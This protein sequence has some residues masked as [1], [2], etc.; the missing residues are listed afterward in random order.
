MSLPTGNTIDSNGICLV[1]KY[2][3]YTFTQDVTACPCEKITNKIDK[4]LKTGLYI[5]IYVNNNNNYS[6]N[7]LNEKTCLTVD[8]MTGF[9]QTYINDLI[10]TGYTGYNSSSI[11]DRVIYD[12]QNEKYYKIEHKYNVCEVDDTPMWA[13][14]NNLNYSIWNGIGNYWY[15]ETNDCGEATTNQMVCL[16]DINPNSIT[17]ES[18]EDI[19][20]CDT[21]T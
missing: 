16:M 15:Y 10:G 9:T 21:T 5:K 19:Y 18:K 7:T 17:F 4:Y 2:D 13:I 6:E 3:Y 20:V 12:F 8:N 1:K 14:V 11:E